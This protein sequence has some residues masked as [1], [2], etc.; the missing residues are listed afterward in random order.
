MGASSSASSSSS[1]P[2]LEP[3][4]GASTRKCRPVGPK[5]SSVSFLER[6]SWTS[7]ERTRCAKSVATRC[8]TY[9]LS[10]RAPYSAISSAFAETMACAAESVTVRTTSCSSATMRASSAI[11]N[12]AIADSE[13][14]SS[15]ENWMTWSRRFMNSGL[16]KDLMSFELEVRMMYVCRKSTVRPFASVNLPSSKTCR[17][18]LKMSGCAFSASSSSTTLYGFLRTASVSWP[19]SSWP[20]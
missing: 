12:F 3:G 6:F 11:W 18:V 2:R 10:G 5:K 8:S 9:L 4:C 17:N 7:P 16:K 13:P 20:M 1:S 14:R 19:P 15:G